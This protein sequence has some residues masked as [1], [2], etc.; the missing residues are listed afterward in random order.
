MRKIQSKSTIFFKKRPTSKSPLP[1]LTNNIVT[2][3]KDPI[4]V[5]ISD[6]EIPQS[7]SESFSSYEINS[8]GKIKQIPTFKSSK[9]D[10]YYSLLLD[11]LFACQNIVPFNKSNFNSMESNLKTQYLEEILLLIHRGQHNN[12][13]DSNISKELFKMIKINLFRSTLSIPKILKFSSALENN[14]NQPLIELSWIHLAYIYRILQRLI[15][16]PLFILNNNHKNF[17]NNKSIKHLIQLFESPDKRERIEVK[18]TIYLIFM[19]IIEYQPII[20]NSLLNLLKESYEIN[21]KIFDLTDFIELITSIYR[22]NSFNNYKKLFFT[23]ILKNHQSSYFKNYNESWFHCLHSMMMLETKYLKQFLEIL[24]KQWPITDTFKEV[25]FLNFINII[26]ET[27]NIR[28]QFD[29]II[30][31]IKQIS[32]CIQSQAFQVVEAA[33]SLWK[34]EQFIQLI[35][36]SANELFPI[37][38]PALYFSGSSHWSNI[39]RNFSVSVIRINMQISQKQFQLSCSDFKKNQN[40][41]LINEEKR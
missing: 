36:D 23:L 27:T 6:L 13:F 22:E 19:S 7:I 16:G 12:L 29:L 34:K 40:I 1:P 18:R 35:A 21:D 25:L 9:D 14:N 5:P 10:Q 28:D 3:N 11:K 37:L 2:F 17:F 41:I 30:P 8:Y 15:S 33:L 24:L 39:I 38:L 31:V 32:I 26:I 20:I 4:I